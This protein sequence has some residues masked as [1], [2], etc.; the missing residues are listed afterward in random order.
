[1]HAM[2]ASR[3]ACQ[4]QPRARKEA[5]Q[6]RRDRAL[7]DT[8]ERGRWR[9][10][11]EGRVEGGMGLEKGGWIGRMTGGGREKCR[12]ERG[13]GKEGGREGGKLRE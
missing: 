2:Q 6:S 5:T 13:L 8:Q 3:R 12:W 11:L 4:C 1:M 10:T 7:G 9:G